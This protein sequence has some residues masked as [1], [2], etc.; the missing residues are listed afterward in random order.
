MLT[1]KHVQKAVA[2]YYGVRV[3]EL[4]GHRRHRGIIIPRQIA[5][6]LSRKLCDASYPWIGRCFDNKDHSTVMHACRKIGAQTQRNPQLRDVVQRIEQTLAP[7][8]SAPTAPPAPAPA[9]A[10]AR[11]AAPAGSTAP[12]QDPGD[13]D[14]D[15]WDCAEDFPLFHPNS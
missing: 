8:A 2:D 3:A 13:D 4:C 15:Y 9:P 5:M 1:I 10:Q 11:P 6:Y 14:A 7:L 12:R